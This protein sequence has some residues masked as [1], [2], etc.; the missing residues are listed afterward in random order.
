MSG[1]TFIHALVI[2]MAFG[3]S[4]ASSR[5]K[6]P[7]ICG[8]PT[9]KARQKFAYKE[10]MDYTYRYTMT[11]N[12]NFD[13]A[14]P[15][16]TELQF[17]FVF[18][19]QFKSKCEG[20]LK[21]ESAQIEY[22]SDGNNT[23]VPHENVKILTKNILRFYYDD[24]T[25]PEICPEEED[26]LW[27]VNIKRGLLTIMQNTMDR[28]DIDQG[29]MER[30]VNGDCFAGYF[31][32]E[33]N[34]TTLVIDKKIDV[35]S[36][37]NRYQIYSIVPMTPY[38]FQK[39]YHKWT[40]M[41]S[42]IFCSQHIDHKILTIINCQERHEYQPFYNQTN[43]AK[44]AARS[45]IVLISETPTTLPDQE[46]I[47]NLGAVAVRDNLLFDHRR[48]LK[49]NNDNL[50]MCKKLLVSLCDINT[51]EFQ[52]KY[53]EYFTK[54]IHVAR[55][56][57]LP[58]LGQLFYESN[59]ICES[60]RMHMLDALPYIRSRAS[61]KI[62][63]DIIT[64]GTTNNATI[65]E[66]LF[67]MA[68]VPRPDAETIDAVAKL[69]LS[70]NW[71]APAALTVSTMIHNFCQRS[72]NCN[73]QESVV[74]VMEKLEDVT[75]ESCGSHNHNEKVYS[76]LKAIGNAGVA[77]DT[78]NLTLQDCIKNPSMPTDVK[79]LSIEAHRRL[80]CETNREFLLDLFKNR[81]A[82]GE[83]R[84]SAY[85]QIMR[86]PTYAI[87]KAIKTTLESEEFNQVGSFVWSHL[88]TT[89][90][91]S[92]PNR[93]EVQA[94]LEDEHFN[95]K[96]DKD[97]RKYSRNYESSFYLNQYGVG[98]FMETNILFSRKSFIPK[99]V[100]FNITINLFGETL[101]ICEVTFFIQGMDA[102]AEKIFNNNALFNKEL[103][104]KALKLVRIIRNSPNPIQALIDELPY[105]PAID[106]IKIS[107]SLKMF[108]NEL[109]YSQI[110]GID[111]FLEELKKLNPMRI[112]RNFFS[113]QEISFKTSSMLV[114][115]YY[116]TPM[117]I[118]LPLRLNSIGTATIK[119]DA[120]GL[121]NATKF[122]SDKE[123]FLKGKL[124]PSIGLSLK[125][126]MEVDAFVATT[127]I[128]FKGTVYTSTA[129]EGSFVTKKNLTFVQTT[130][131]LPLEKSD[132]VHAETH[133]ILI[134]NDDERELAGITAGR[135]EKRMCSW[136]IID[137]TIGLKL[138]AHTLLPNKE[139]LL[140][141]P[142]FLFSGP[143]KLGVTLEKSDPTAKLYIVEY[144]LDNVN[145]KTVLMFKF[146]TP[147]S[148]T[149]R[150]M[151]AMI[152]LDPQ[153]QNL[154]LAYKS[155]LS[156]VQ[157]EGYYR[158]TPSEKLINFGLDINGVK[159]IDIQIGVNITEE[160]YG[161]TYHPRLLFAI[162]NK[163]IVSLSGS[164]S[165]VKKKG[166]SQCHIELDFQTQRFA[167]VISGYGRLSEVSFAT[168]IKMDYK[169]GTG[170]IETVKIE[171]KLDNRSTKFLTNYTT[172]LQLESTAYPEI[173]FILSVKFQKAQ[174]HVDCRLNMLT[175]PYIKDDKQKLRVRW[176]LQQFKAFAIN[177][178]NTSLEIIKP[179]S[180][181]DI[182]LGFIKQNTPNNS[183]SK[184]I[185]RYATGK[186]II[187]TFDLNIPHGSLFYFENK[188]KV[189]LMPSKEQMSV[190][191]KI[192]EKSPNDYDVEFA[193][194]W[195]SG[196]NLTVRGMLQDQSD[197]YVSSYNFKILARSQLFNDLLLSGKYLN[198]EEEIKTDLQAEHNNINYGLGFRHLSEIIG[199]YETFAEIKYDTAVYSFSNFLDLIKRRTVLELHLDQYRDVHIS[200]HGITNKTILDAGL[201]VKWD[202]N[203]D[204]SQKLT[205]ILL[206]NSYGNLN[207]DGKCI[208]EYPGRLITSYFNMEHKLVDYSLFAK[209]QWSQKDIIVSVFKGI[210]DMDENRFAKIEG[211]VETP[212]TNW[213]HTSLVYQIKF[214]P[215]LMKSNGTV[216]WKTDQKFDME[217]SYRYNFT[218]DNNF[219][220]FISEINSTIPEV[221]SMKGI[222]KYAQIENKFVTELIIQP[223]P[224]NKFAV[225][226][227]GEKMYAT[228]YSYYHAFFGIL[229]P[230]ETM[231]AATINAGLY[232]YPMKRF[233]GNIQFTGDGKKYVTT[234]DGSFHVLKE[235]K[236]NFH[237]NTPFEKY[238]LI[239]GRY[240]FSAS[241]KR[242]FLDLKGPTVSAGADIIYVYNNFSNFD[243]KLK[244]HASV[245]LVSLLIVGKRD[246]DTID[247]RIGWN[248][249]LVGFIGRSHYIA[250]H[251]V[252]YSL[253]LFT[254]FEGYNKGSA[255]AKLIYNDKLDLETYV[256][257]GEKKI[258]LKVQAM[259]KPDPEFAVP[260][261][262]D[263][264]SRKLISGDKYIEPFNYDEIE[265][266]N[267][268]WRGVFQF[269]STLYPTVH[270][271]VQVNDDGVEYYTISYLS[272]P[273]GQV[274]ITD[275]LKYTDLLNLKNFM[276]VITT[277][278][279]LDN[280]EVS[281][282]IGGTLGRNIQ[283]TLEASAKVYNTSYKGE[284]ETDYLYIPVS[285]ENKSEG[286]Y[287]ITAR[288]KTP[289]RKLAHAYTNVL[290]KAESPIYVGNLTV[291]MNNSTVYVDGTLENDGTIFTMD[292]G[293]KINTTIFKLPMCRLMLS[294]DFTDF[295][296][297][298]K[299][300][301]AL[302]N[303]RGDSLVHY[304]IALA[305]HYDGPQYLKYVLSILTPYPSIGTIKTSVSY[306]SDPSF[307]EYFLEIYVKYS[308]LNEIT[309]WSSVKKQMFN[310]HVLSTS[311]LIRNISINGVLKNKGGVRSLDAVLSWDKEYRMLGWAT[312][313]SKKP[314]MVEIKLYK[315]A[316]NTEVFGL[317]L[318]VHKK[319]NRYD[320]NSLIQRFDHR[321]NILCDYVIIDNIGKLLHVM[322]SSTYPGYEKFVLYSEFLSKDSE[323]M[324]TQVNGEVQS[325][326][327]TTQA[328]VN[329]N[330]SLEEDIGIIRLNLFNKN[331]S[332]DGQISWVNKALE[333]LAF[334]I[335]G[336]VKYFDM[337][338]TINAHIHMWNFDSEF[339]EMSL[340]S[341]VDYNSK[342]WWLTA[343]ATLLWPVWNDLEFV[344]HAILPHK[345]ED[346]HITLAKLYYDKKMAYNTLLLKYS[347][348]PKSFNFHSLIE[349]V[350]EPETMHGTVLM[351]TGKHRI[352]D[353]L[354]TVSTGNQYDIRN[355][356]QS[357]N[358]K[359]DLT[360]AVLYGKTDKHKVDLTV[361]YPEP[362]PYVR[363]HTE[364]SALNNLF[365]TMNCTTPFKAFPHVRVFLKLI[366]TRPFYQRYIE[367]FWANQSAQLNYTHAS[368]WEKAVQIT[369][370][371]VLI[372]F[373]LTSRHTGLL[374]YKYESTDS[375]AKGRSSLSYNKEVIMSGNY[376]RKT[377]FTDRSKNEVINISVNNSYLPTGIIYINDYRQKGPQKLFPNR[378]LKRIELYKLSNVSTFNITGEI[379]VKKNVLERNVTF[380]IIHAKRKVVL[381]TIYDGK[382]VFIS[383]ANF[384]LRPSIWGACG[385]NVYTKELIPGKTIEF[386]IAYPR[387][388]FSLKG[389]Y[390]YTD[391]LL[392]TEITLLPN[393]NKSP[394]QITGGVYYIRDP[395]ENSQNISFILAHPSFHKNLT[396]I[397]RHMKSDKFPLK[398]DLDFE[399]SSDINKKL[400]FNSFVENKTTTPIIHYEYNAH[401]DHPASR[402]RL[403]SFGYLKLSNKMVD[404]RENVTYKR[405]YVPL[406]FWFNGL[407]VDVN[408]KMFELERNSLRELSYVYGKYSKDKTKH[409]INGVLLNGKDTKISGEYMLD[410]ANSLTE[411]DV[412]LTADASEKL[413]MKG[414]H[415][416]SRHSVLDIWRSYDDLFVS[417]LHFS[418]NLN[419][420]RLLTSYLIWRPE[421]QSDIVDLILNI[422]NYIMNYATETT[423]FWTNYFKTEIYD[424]TMDIWFD[425]KP[426]IQDFLDDI[427]DVSDLQEDIAIFKKI[428]MQS[429]EENEFYM[430]DIY[431]MYLD[432]EQEMSFK[433]RMSHV[434]KIVN[435]LWEVMGETGETIRQSI[436]WFVE[437]IK[438]VYNKVAEFVRGLIT[439]ETIDKISEYLQKIAGKYDK[440]IRE[441]HISF[442]HYVEQLWTD[443]V[444]IIYNYW[445]KTLK[446]IEP[447]FIQFAHHT[448]TVFWE[449]SKKIL[450]FLYARQSELLS[451][452]V[453]MKNKNFTKNLDVFYED[454]TNNDFLTNLKKY[455]K[456]L[457]DLIREQYFSAVP[458]G[459]E[460]NEIGSEI[461]GEMKEL[462]KLPFLNF[463]IDLTR[464][465]YNK[466][467]WIYN[468]F[469]INDKLQRVVPV[470][471]NVITDYSHT[472][473]E[474]ELINHGA[475]TKFVFEPD[476]GKIILE[477]KLPM[478][479]HA[480]NETPNYE[481]IMEYKILKKVQRFISPSNNSFW[482]YYYKLA[483][484][485]EPSKWFP[486]FSGQAII[487]SGVHFVTFD[488]NHVE[489]FDDCS[490]LLA[491]DFVQN[492]FSLVLKHEFSNNILILITKDAVINV[493]LQKQIVSLEN[494]DS[495]FLPLQIGDTFI[496]AE[497]GIV[498]IQNKNGI[499]LHCNF[500]YEVC[501]FELSGWY[502]GKTAGLLG[503]VDNEPKTDFY[504]SDGRLK[505]N[506]R[507][508]IES[509]KI[510][511]CMRI[512]EVTN[513]SNMMKDN[514][515]GTEICQALFHAKSS[516]FSSCYPVINPQPFFRICHNKLP[517]RY[518]DGICTSAYAYIQACK[519]KFVP[520]KMPTSCVLCPLLYG[521]IIQEGDF[522]RLESDLVPQSTDVV[523]IMEAK[524]CNQYMRDRRMVHTFATILAK[525]LSNVGIA[526][527]RY[528]V[529]TYG[530]DGVFDQP[531]NI[532]VKNQVF[533]NENDLPNYFEKIV[534]GN[535]NTDIFNALRYATKLQYRAGVSKTFILIPCSDC[536][537]ANMTIEY[538]VLNQAFLEQN[539]TLHVLM[540]ADF[541]FEKL[542]VNKMFYGLD[543]ERAFTKSDFKVM[544]GDMDLRRQIK[545]TKSMM[546]YCTT[547]ALETNGTIFTGKRMGS[548]NLALV[549]KF[550]SVFARRIAASAQPDSCQHCEC[551]ANSEGIDFVDCIPCAIPV[552]AYTD[553]DFQENGTL[554]FWQAFEPDNF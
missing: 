240:A 131:N 60:G 553:F 217:V 388:Y 298:L 183:T 395:D 347:A 55:D 327:I 325:K 128:K 438:K 513:F 543:S 219:I 494:R 48:A 504:A 532:V 385:F 475:R 61:T 547:L 24:G 258:G 120:K 234:V 134:V 204:P 103:F 3:Q 164:I 509:W 51:M 138:C 546:G 75:S 273:F 309:A 198:R 308:K 501:L 122:S 53:T 276:N 528:A 160:K 244:A 268:Y 384:T 510:G 393:R 370:G 286:F 470:L 23:M 263:V 539:I 272:F 141:S 396:L 319:D 344:S 59:Y 450:E 100:N 84:I 389:N 121:I 252:D 245:S 163:R 467:R 267:T 381:D 472:A 483:P 517:N 218:T 167:T 31:F 105:F 214:D 9:C 511:N 336:M 418:T 85:L 129:L 503:T 168:N 142:L 171:L 496:Y 115:I 549:K 487:I 516:S 102:V 126:A 412:N 521:D 228:D 345:T 225:E 333:H 406:S 136:S 93:V 178:L 210:Y 74:K 73:K 299:V 497:E 492:T 6:D 161:N 295:E 447:T 321:I 316:T 191:V 212:F 137:E 493:N 421:I 453:F 147:G 377:T 379:E 548:E 79:I 383:T 415:R 413:S 428:F 538:N 71:T 259:K 452:P 449:G 397:A 99:I 339:Q 318:S 90:K 58:T 404:F 435:E 500:K 300:G 526:K 291:E 419:H 63:T 39:K 91:S 471:Y 358:L 88:K 226:L 181:I 127:G 446:V 192:F 155:S 537:L 340:A 289:F 86:C 241:N 342:E 36:C 432:L 106:D 288:A 380:R 238:T 97:F 261:S 440:M 30:D 94:M 189:L 4:I 196:H 199:V 460:L 296:K 182:K 186:E 254:P 373:P 54:F 515:T 2:L 369:D 405:S 514:I 407:K 400:T 271:I 426:I 110:V 92:F 424:S 239:T 499:K 451:S 67:I 488:G 162:N 323:T 116:V 277:C 520:L 152:D 437:S 550:S 175:N 209:V 366:T 343:N 307:E 188:I 455:T 255:I 368:T 523:F 427:R 190:C 353:H 123:L 430:Q 505:T 378:D 468:Y 153:T 459:Y 527:N 145:N 536:D 34:G 457:I 5:F 16:S 401:G 476:R 177:K 231:R 386:I 13:G 482:T 104:E 283:A 11:T 108:G 329:L 375:D 89:M 200:I 507:E 143:L 247:V 37:T 441:L 490:Y 76:A 302:P 350:I 253:Q 530:G 112:I 236:L 146:D 348:N 207:Y 64:D 81:S 420:S 211:K 27:V 320:I 25:I 12:V 478:P 346:H 477:Q 533:T 463:T 429:Y 461:V 522:T 262:E 324:V 20:I 399:Y 242:F 44:T 69:V 275:T 246:L 328:Q 38:V 335:S 130:F 193:G 390:E 485:L 144:K 185:V 56:L 434:P 281:F 301:L 150:A 222:L 66:W 525:E 282:S 19:F 541:D 260:F 270:G 534:S 21:I 352:Y 68:F 408:H 65:T 431:K 187:L 466:T 338:R 243:L 118:G 305:W 224:A 139:Q 545:L 250:W 213:E 464:E 156:Q 362:V 337:P 46:L 170:S 544:K 257:L 531:H 95:D 529:V 458:F 285:E 202:A 32:R 26:P 80:P 387:R 540:N 8:R 414:S 101:N 331:I 125:A 284:L 78:L 173:N 391:D 416:E 233:K 165:W 508:F 82:E 314:F 304:G 184:V 227:L 361:Y 15:D 433:D 489:T 356:L 195:F 495:F 364:F 135:E 357:T 249:L 486:P 235:S 480:F 422:T 279:C 445:T 140:K 117:M 274:K 216:I 107:V 382:N 315:T 411:L 303:E 40:P 96:F 148:N 220:V 443:T 359:E 251:D 311:E 50:I 77:T 535:G 41:N 484:L 448:E 312:V 22:G 205:A 334:D 201:D 518:K 374:N 290:L 409:I 256:N 72:K 436:L 363:M 354:I 169:F 306:S 98:G 542:R 355:V 278:N 149:K 442:L 45:E 42:S 52:P 322:L 313:N 223:S 265:Y 519:E 35:N 151:T 524:E 248:T 341:D 28:F 330:V 206:S 551:M 349:V 33:V 410:I 491:R 365:A 159:H 124:V 111:Q 462:Y 166:L 70:A 280:G 14:G 203:R 417:D 479:W 264:S 114:D 403:T 360:V 230:F 498:T 392:T 113:G 158:N 132:I 194:V 266:G 512:K 506:S 332:A 208:I 157:A 133:L 62:M 425:A 176:D 317:S 49:T 57:S 87:L 292:V 83:V 29:V 215:Q 465:V 287:N 229:T 47:K 180:G 293:A 456:M 172:Q 7:G 326:W 18:K 237:I 174:S 297:E 439:G 376:S 454:I 17:D 402:L 394:T 469:N 179:N 119:I 473:L 310:F 444:N 481:E 10:K 552:P 221:N 269:D 232:L 367:V 474:N 154:T 554:S 371:N 351:Q 398:F 423:N 109:S 372:D 502:F 294:K 197:P 1:S 43:G